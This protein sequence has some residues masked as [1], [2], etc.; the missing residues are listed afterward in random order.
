MHENN[1]ADKYSLIS[2][3]IAAQDIDSSLKINF[4]HHKNQTT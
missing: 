2:L 3:I 4:N 1:D